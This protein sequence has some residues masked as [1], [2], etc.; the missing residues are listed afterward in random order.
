MPKSE[1]S[2]TEIL[3]VRLRPDQKSNFAKCAA[4]RGLASATHAYNLLIGDMA[5]VRP[6][7]EQ[8]KGATRRPVH[9][10]NR[11]TFGVRCSRRLV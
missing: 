3:R 11:E 7:T 5:H 1:T 2:R 6:R 9:F 4:A 8:R 10:P